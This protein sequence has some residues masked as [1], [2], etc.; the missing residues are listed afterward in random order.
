LS[1]CEQTQQALLTLSLIDQTAIDA[2]FVL[3][4]REL[5]IKPRSPQIFAI[6]ET[7]F[8]Q[9]TRSIAQLIDLSIFFHPIKQHMPSMPIK[10]A[11]PP[12]E[13]AESRGG[14]VN[15]I[16]T[17]SL[18]ES[19]GPENYKRQIP[20]RTFS[21]WKR[22]EGGRTS[23]S[24][25][26]LVPSGGQLWPRA[27]RVFIRIRPNSQ[28]SRVDSPRGPLKGGNFEQNLANRSLSTCQLQRCARPT[29]SVR[30]RALYAPRLWIFYDGPE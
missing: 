18:T 11:V 2:C 27:C 13:P 6:F 5:L 8:S 17:F 29:L 16:K 4:G 14:N 20:A 28:S 30:L 25:L 3:F 24:D 21:S 7:L 9:P 12:F 15:C 1:Q 19:A 10:E 26:T 22:V 23:I